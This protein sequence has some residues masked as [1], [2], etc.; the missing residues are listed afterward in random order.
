MNTRFH[1]LMGLNDDEEENPPTILPGN[2]VVMD[3]QLPFRPLSKF[4]N[5]FLN[6]LQCTRQRNK[7][8]AEVTLIDTPGILSGEK[9]T[10]ERLAGRFVDEIFSDNSVC[11]EVTTL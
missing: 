7:L 2:A 8:L 1:I 6:R 11:S 9:Q 5:N 4:G 3:P 10:T